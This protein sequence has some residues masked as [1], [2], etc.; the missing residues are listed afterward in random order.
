MPGRALPMT[1]LLNRGL[2]GLG[3]AYGLLAVEP[4]SAQCAM[5]RSA[6]ESLEGQAIASA[7][8]A[9]VVVLLATPI[10]SFVTIA[11]MAVRRQRRSGS[12]GP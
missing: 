6:L 7:F 8:R 9:S 11:V 4:A 12:R 2:L 5:C 3:L 1:K 10:L